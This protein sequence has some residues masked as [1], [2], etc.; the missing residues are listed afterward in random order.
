MSKITIKII[1]VMITAF[2]IVTIITPFVPMGTAQP[3]GQ[4]TVLLTVPHST[5][6]VLN[7]TDLVAL[8]ASNGWAG[9]GSAE[10][11]YVIEGLDIDAEGSAN[12]MFIGNTALHLM[13]QGCYL[14][15]TSLSLGAMPF[16]GNCG[17]TIYNGRNITLEDNVCS[18]AGRGIALS[19][20]QGIIVR[21]NTCVDNLHGLSLYNSNGNLLGG[22]NCSSDGFDGIHS[23]GSLSNIIDGNLCTQNARYG[24]CLTSVC[25]NNTV[26]NNTCAN[27][28][29]AGIRVSSS[30]VDNTVIDNLL[31]GN[32][33]YGIHI[34]SA[35]NG[36][37]MFGNVLSR[38]RG[39]TTIFD[40]SKV[41]AYDDS[42]NSWNST[43][44]GNRWYDWPKPDS[45]GDGI[46]DNVYAIDG[47]SNSDTLPI[48]SAH[49]SIIRPTDG[50]VVNTSTVIVTG[51]SDPDYILSINSALV[52]VEENGSF[53]YALSLLEGTN[54][55]E[56]RSL[57]PV[58]A[59]SAFVNVTYINEL[60]AGLDELNGQVDEMD[61]RI[62]ALNQSLNAA[63]DDL[64]AAIESIGALE[65]NLNQTREWLQAVES[66]LTACYIEQNLTAT[67][68]ASLIEQ[69]S[70]LKASLIELRDSLNLTDEQMA[71]LGGSLDA[72]IADLA[73]AE[74]HL[75][76]LQ[77][78]VNEI[79]NDDLPLILGAV[80]F[81]LG[82]LALV[83]FVLV[84]TRKIK[85]P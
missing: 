12:A 80:G 26:I 69:V 19:S 61:Q 59:V 13:V 4:A 56:A 41:Q 83:L 23:E 67:E 29:N 85:L 50:E 77:T 14:H 53:S 40:I 8:I 44:H 78:E 48:A 55:I 57:N 82:I 11:P 10:H 32:I 28:T 75:E 63:I 24:I 81:V 74:Y 71:E 47:G 66:E 62:D 46:V 17:V 22:N 39:A 33:G 37:V 5:I 49:V 15:N 35:C 30:S 79:K 21:N 76:S 51:I 18:G 72:A 42:T 73:S 70:S 54:V 65:T 7:D 9:D 52:Y 58:R 64:D 36:N 1:S 38:N 31:T 2:F 43:A 25:I 27:N 16:N 84:F 3:E 20:S 6:S 34:T 45:N 60:R 68:V